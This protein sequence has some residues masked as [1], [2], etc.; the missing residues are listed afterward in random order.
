MD[1]AAW[2]Q[3]FQ[4]AVLQLQ[5]LQFGIWFSV[6]LAVTLAA[7]YFGS[8]NVR[9]ARLIEDV[10]TSKT[11]SAAQGYVELIGQA[12][13]LDGPPITSP[14][15]GK[16]CLWY[17]YEIEKKIRSGKSSRWQTIEKGISDSLFLLKDGT[18]HCV[19][20][21]E[22]ADVTTEQQRQW[23]G[24][25]SRPQQDITKSSTGLSWL[26]GSGRY[27]YKEALLEEY[28][29]LYAI[30]LFTT[31]GRDEQASSIQDEVRELIR[32]WKRD[33]QMI[34]KFDSNNDGQID[35]EEWDALR[36]AAHQAVMSSQVKSTALP[37]VHVMQ[38]P[39][40]GRPFLLFT[41]DPAVMV[42][43]L[44]WSGW[45]FKLSAVL[46]GAVALYMLTIRLG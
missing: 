9:R 21:P 14:L 12:M 7:L 22:G 35:L 3:Q 6:L 18:G 36:Q 45:C 10:P 31:V 29:P 5:P 8:R 15:T 43:Q 17:R 34:A 39:K 11:R 2:L 28:D 32:K 42:R 16:T 19:V 41:H 38:K 25:S 30:G 20:D 26:V 46:V 4:A 1:Q 33:P 13:P 24:Q 40:D 37:A 23:Y 44:R 27:R